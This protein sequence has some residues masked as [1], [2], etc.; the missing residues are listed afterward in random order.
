M[1]FIIK[2]LKSLEP[3]SAR[4]YNSILVIVNRLTKASYFVPIEETIIAEEMAYEV[5][6]LLVAYYGLSKQFII[7]RGTLFTSKY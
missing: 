5:T 4:L 3:R 1:D 2:L 7:D 6:K